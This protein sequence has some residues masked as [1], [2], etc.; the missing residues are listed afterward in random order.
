MSIPEKTA[1]DNYNYSKKYLNHTLNDW[2]QNLHKLHCEENKWQYRKLNPGA[3]GYDNL[4][5]TVVYALNNIQKQI[6]SRN[7]KNNLDL[8]L[9]AKSIHKGWFINY[10]YWRDNNPEN[11]QNENYRAPYKP[12]GDERRNKCADTNYEDLPEE[13]KNKDILLAKL[14]IKLYAIWK[15]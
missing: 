5:Y 13:E 3:Y 6:K 11:R 15:K 4:I 10:V 12:L 2:V 1:T 14:M 8:N 9:I 7:Y